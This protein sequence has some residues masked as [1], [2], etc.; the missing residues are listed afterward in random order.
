LLSAGALYVRAD[1]RARLPVML[2]SGVEARLLLETRLPVARPTDVVARLLV[3]TRLRAEVVLTLRFCFVLLLAAGRLRDRLDWPPPNAEEAVPKRIRREPATASAIDIFFLT[4][5][6]SFSRTTGTSRLLPAG[7]T[8]TLPP[9]VAS[10]FPQW[11]RILAILTASTFFKI[12]ANV[13]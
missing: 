1:V 9:L 5:V 8:S 10:R 2:R 13:Q 6:T 7:S 4:V 3:E 12:H 11:P